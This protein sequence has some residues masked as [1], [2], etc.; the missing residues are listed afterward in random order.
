MLRGTYKKAKEFR[1]PLRRVL[2]TGLCVGRHHDPPHGHRSDNIEYAPLGLKRRKASVK[3]LLRNGQ[4]YPGPTP[5]TPAGRMR[6]A[7]EV[8]WRIRE[9]GPGKLGEASG[10]WTDSHTY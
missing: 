3:V 4:Q 6:S 5:P 7:L 10:P 1:P 9:K 2:A 8:L